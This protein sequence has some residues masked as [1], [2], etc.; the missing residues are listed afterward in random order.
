[1]AS[2]AH[3]FIADLIARRMNL[4]GY[5]VVGFEGASEVEAIK[6]KLPPKIL[7]HRPDLIGIKPS[8]VAIGEAKTADD[9]TVRTLEQL[10]DFTNDTNWSNQI[11]H[12]VFFGIPMSVQ[13]KFQK[14][15]KD[16]GV[17]DENLTILPVPDRLLPYEENV[18]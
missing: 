15:I 3:Q 1:M 11:G 8:G 16:L 5:E 14:I 12:Q 17:N 4:E 2:K 7:R 13:D 6:L 9:L 10:Q 18:I